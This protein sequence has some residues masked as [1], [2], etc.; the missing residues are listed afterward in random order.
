MT[1][2]KIVS[3]LT[4]TCNCTFIDQANYMHAAAI[5]S[6]TT[7]SPNILSTGL[8]YFTNSK[9]YHAEMDAANKLKHNDNNKRIDLIVIRIDKQNN[10]C[11]SMPCSNCMYY[12]H[13]KFK[14]CKIR[15]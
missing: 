6:V 3:D 11:N 4:K 12:L 2:S 10:L 5:I 8:N 14:Y 13:E 9:N 7:K 1:F 15:P